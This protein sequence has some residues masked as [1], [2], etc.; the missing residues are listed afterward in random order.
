MTLPMT[1]DELTVQI[2]ALREYRLRLRINDG[3]RAVVDA[4]IFRELDALTKMETSREQ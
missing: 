4:L 2:E 3:R 1:K